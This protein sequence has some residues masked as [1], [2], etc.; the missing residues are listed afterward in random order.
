MTNGKEP[1][2]NELAWYEEYAGQSVALTQDSP[3]AIGVIN[4]KLQRED[5]FVLNDMVIASLNHDGGSAEHR[6]CNICTVI[7]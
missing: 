2:P 3:D 6:G 4:G 7:K 5:S 1:L